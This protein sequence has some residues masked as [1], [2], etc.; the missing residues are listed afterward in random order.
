MLLFE[1]LVVAV[2]P[3]SDHTISA[4][5]NFD[6]KI[7]FFLVIAIYIKVSSALM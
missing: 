1:F 4:N 2:G 3:T 5:F 6:P 7:V